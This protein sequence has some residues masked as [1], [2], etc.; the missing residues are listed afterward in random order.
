MASS[1]SAKAC[2]M[3]RDCISLFERRGSPPRSNV[4][5]PKPSTVDVP[6]IARTSKLVRNSVIPGI[7]TLEPLATR[8]A[9]RRI[10]RSH[11]RQRAIEPLDLDY[12]ELSSAALRQFRCAGVSDQHIRIA[13]H[14]DRVVGARGLWRVLGIVPRA[15]RELDDPGAQ[16]AA[17]H[18][19]GEAGAAIV[20][21]AHDVAVTDA[22]GCRILRVH[23]DGLAPPELGRQ[24]GGA[25]IQLAVQ[26]G[27][28]LIGDELQRETRIGAL[29]RRQP[30]RVPGAVGVAE[31]RNPGRRDLDLAAR[32]R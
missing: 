23:A 5:T 19:A 21:E 7:W 25:K 1:T 13:V 2:M 10:E 17:Q 22:P 11:R 29:A 8:E 30:G 9:S 6:S 31:P 32:R 4:A 16:R 15:G 24:A 27:G 3:T 18:R 28:R 26:P 12:R 14:A 20:V